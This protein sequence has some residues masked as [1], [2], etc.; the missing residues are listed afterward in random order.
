MRTTRHGTE[1]PPAKSLHQKHHVAFQVIECEAEVATT[2]LSARCILKGPIDENTTTNRP[3]WHNA[4]KQNLHRKAE[5]IQQLI[6]S[7][8]FDHDLA[9][10]NAEDEA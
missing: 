5:I 4:I 8:R 10:H 3:V 7:D 9:R 1:G 6:Q 2:A